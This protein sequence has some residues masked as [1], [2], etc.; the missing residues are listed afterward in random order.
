MNGSLNYIWRKGLVILL[1]S[2]SNFNVKAH[3]QEDSAY[4]SYG[5]QPEWMVNSATSSVTGSVLEKSFTTNIA[6]TLYGKLPGLFMLQTS[7]EFGSD[8]P[9]MFSRGISTFSTGRSMLM[10]IDGHEVPDGY[11][12]QLVPEEIE[13]ITLLKDAAATALY[14]SKGAN[15]VLLITTK[16]G[17][18]S[19]LKINFKA[20]LGFQ[21]ALRLPK[22]LD[23]YDYASLYNEALNNDGK[24]S[25][26]SQEALDAYSNGSNP[27]VYP[28]VDWYDAVLRNNAPIM[29]Y[30]FNASGG[31]SSIKYFVLLNVVTSEGLYNKTKKLSEYTENSKY[32]RYNFRTNVDLNLTKRLSASITVAGTV[33]DKTLPGISENTNAEFDLLASVPSNSFPIFVGN[34]MYGGNNMYANPFGEITERGYY[35]TNGRLALSSL[36]LKEDLG[37][38]TP[39]LSISGS[40]GFNSFFKSSTIGSHDYQRFI[41]QQIGDD[42]E[43]LPIGEDSGKLNIDESRSFQQRNLTMQAML[44]YERIFNNHSINAVLVTNRDEMTVSEANLPYFNVGFGGRFT[45]AY[46]KRYIGEFS[47]GYNGTDNYPLGSRFGFF[48]AVSLGWVVSNEKF[49]QNNDVLNYLK[50]K[51]TYGLTGNSDIGGNRYMYDQY[52]DWGGFYPFGDANSNSEAFVEG[53]LANPNVTWEKEKHFN[54]GFNAILFKHFELGFDYF[55]RNR[56]DILATP[57]LSLPDYAGFKKPLMNVGKVNNKGFELNMKYSNTIDKF[58][59]FV[60]GGLWFSR[61]KIKYN[62][63]GM[64]QYDYMYR[65]GHSIDQ[66]F[67]LQA[68]GFFE[69][70]ED[71][72]K[73]PVHTFMNVKPGDIKYKDLNSDGMINENDICAIGHTNLPELTFGLDLGFSYKGFDF[74]ANLQGVGNRSIYRNGRYYEAFRN[75]GN[76]SV[77]ALERWTP[78]TK[79]TATYPRLSAADNQNNYQVSS[80]WQENGSFL[81]LRSLEVGYTLPFKFVKT[82][83]LNNV[84][85]FLNGTNLFSL[86]HM[87]GFTDPETISG[88]PAIR[89]MSVGVNVEL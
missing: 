86:D 73:S 87:N 17:Q 10:V 59:F 68:I 50:L 3:S 33:E 8:N 37:F 41:V 27:V 84:R 5:R 28:N 56:N 88:Y 76:A 71:I 89:T 14:G 35:K 60:Q 77:W 78:E 83:S 48:P 64:Q 85:F 72:D 57:Y 61:N 66:P 40:I 23:A 75:N 49:L 80:F 26:Y 9:Q 32:V 74:T 7:G 20:K 15:G 79:E 2:C 29:N 11:F 47:F 63:E 54:V 13:D 53:V 38:I 12:Q 4:I 69:S 25:L 18:L 58:N 22:F 67:G 82:L 46:D 34:N 62:A 39:G 19:G 31:N 51:V 81:K 65:T 45:Y 42:R 44:N 30:D 21:H 36:V 16:R 70:Q 24:S 1:L 52:Y 43:L 6:N 55:N